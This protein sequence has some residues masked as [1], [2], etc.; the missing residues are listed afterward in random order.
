[1]RTFSVPLA[2]VKGQRVAELAEDELQSPSVEDLLSCLGNQEDV[3]PLI[4]QPGQ[5]FASKDGVHMAAARIQATWK[6]FLTRSHFKN[7]RCRDVASRLIGVAFR[8]HQSRQSSKADI[9]AKWVSD[10]NVWRKRQ[11]DFKRRWKNIQ[12]KRRM[13]IH[14]SSMSRDKLRRHSLE[15]FMTIQNA[16]M[17]RLFDLRDENVELLFISPFPIPDDVRRYYT[18]LLEIGGV[19]NLYKR[20]KFLVPENYEILPPN[21]STSSLLYYSPKC[22]NRIRSLSKGI[23]TYIVPN[24]VGDEDLKVAVFLKLPI[25]SGEPDIVRSF[26]S[27]SGSHR[28]FLEAG[29][30]TPV[31][32]TDVYDRDDLVSALANL[33]VDNLHV[34]RWIIKI[35]NETGG[36][37]LAY[38]EPAKLRVRPHSPDDFVL[39]V[40]RLP[41]N[42]C[43]HLWY[44]SIVLQRNGEMPRR[45]L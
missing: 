12:T 28:V 35:D 33:V 38:F 9:V 15:N 10:L 1:M 34:Q 23:T 32:A 39:V 6:M 21:M 25:L 29:I 8:L 41:N 43:I 36:R 4:S 18:K 44:T 17:S 42:R 3:E 45:R 37:G 26:S 24:E 20:L 2:K 16:Q 40:N 31:G 19:K 11:D 7:L 30:N 14:I 22:L 27:S 5:R 13:V